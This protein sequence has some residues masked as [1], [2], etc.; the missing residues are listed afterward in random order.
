[1][2]AKGHDFPRVTLVGVI[3]ADV[4]LGLPDFRAAERTFQLLTQVAGRAGRAE[5]AGEVILQSHWPDH[6]ALGLACARTTTAS[7]SV[8]WS[9]AAP[10]ATRR[11]RRCVNIVLRAKDAAE[12]ERD[13]AGLARRLREDAPGRYRVLGPAFAPLARLRGEHRFQILLKGQRTAMR[14]AVRKALVDRFG[15]SRWPGVAVDVD[16]VSVM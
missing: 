3:D 11:W 2:I 12:G 1:M 6:Y 8:R 10:W 15:E 16:P 7:S 4:G 13:A 5:L 14:E 9:S